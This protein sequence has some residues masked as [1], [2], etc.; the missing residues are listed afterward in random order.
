M[1][2]LAEVD[3]K[4]SLSKLRLLFIAHRA[5]DANSPKLTSSVL[6]DLRM[7]LGARTGYALT[8]DKVAGAVC[9]TNIFDY[10]ETGGL[11]PFGSP[12]S[13]V[14]INLVGNEEQMSQAEPRGKASYDHDG[15]VEEVC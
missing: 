3:S 11:A 8:T 1:A 7:L 14:E 6:A 15:L 10:R 5:S 4:L 2:K 9:Q 12:I 13:S